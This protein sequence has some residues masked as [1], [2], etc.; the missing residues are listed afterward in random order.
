MDKRAKYTNITIHT[1]NKIKVAMRHH[2][3]FTL[4]ITSRRSD[5]GL[6]ISY[7]YRSS[8]R[9]QLRSLFTG[10]TTDPE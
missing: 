3:S 4:I 10:T 2:S 5:N 6:I 9:R 1:G 8:N 7:L